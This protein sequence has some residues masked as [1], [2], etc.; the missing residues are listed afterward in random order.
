VYVQNQPP[1]AAEPSSPV[2]V[3][4]G[5]GGR[6]GVIE[7]HH[8]VPDRRMMWSG[9]VTLGI[10]YGA[11]LVVA[12]A[13]PHSGDAALYVPVFGPWIDLAGREPCGAGAIPCGDEGANRAG[14][15]IDGLFQALG[16]GLIISAFLLPEEPGTATVV[17][18]A[19]PPKP[20]V[21]LSPT[22]LAH[23]APG[24]ALTGTF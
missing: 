15:V 8:Y 23:G 6:E 17:A 11:G 5:E 20:E 18:K 13:S 21:H 4:N 16:A 24:M 10:S 22:T 7:H 9:L 3:N 12:G 2:V 1:P 19:A 14:L